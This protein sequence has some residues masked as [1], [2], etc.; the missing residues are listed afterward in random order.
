MSLKNTGFKFFAKTMGGNYV[1]CCS[2]QISF[3]PTSH[4]KKLDFICLPHI[5]RLILI[6]FFWLLKKSNMKKSHHN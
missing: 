6:S 5:N 2:S 4:F 1:F 3:N